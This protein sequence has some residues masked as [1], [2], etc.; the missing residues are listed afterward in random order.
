MLLYNNKKKNKKS[1]IFKNKFKITYKT[2]FA[3]IP[4]VP[5]KKHRSKYI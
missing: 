5:N 2:K 4:K 3:L 1:K